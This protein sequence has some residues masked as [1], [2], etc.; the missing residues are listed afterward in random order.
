M[1][2]VQSYFYG[3]YGANRARARLAKRNMAVRPPTS[4]FQ[5]ARIDPID[6]GGRTGSGG[7]QISVAAPRSQRG[8]RTYRVGGA[9]R[10]PMRQNLE[11]ILQRG[12]KSIRS[13]MAFSLDTICVLLGLFFCA[14]ECTR[15]AMRTMYALVCV[16]VFVCMLR[17]CG[18]CSRCHSACE[19]ARIAV[20]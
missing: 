18:S 13:T 2:A 10:R 16:C 3:R 7:R 6:W 11:D 12:A 9:I 4:E 5:S 1:C 20:K 14:N 8:A 15:A 19:R 17:L